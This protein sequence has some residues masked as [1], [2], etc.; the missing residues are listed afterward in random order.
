VITEHDT[1]PRIPSARPEDHARVTNAWAR[2]VEL[3]ETLEGIE[4]SIQSTSTKVR[5]HAALGHLYACVH[6][7]RLAHDSE[8]RGR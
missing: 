1:E 3:L 7:I 5:I 8:R 4:A 2:A 6:E